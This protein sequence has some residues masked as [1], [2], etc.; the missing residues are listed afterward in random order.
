MI[1]KDNAKNF[2]TK[3]IIPLKEQTFNKYKDFLTI[4]YPIHPRLL[5]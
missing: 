1:F 3:Y 5:P 2:I 4:N